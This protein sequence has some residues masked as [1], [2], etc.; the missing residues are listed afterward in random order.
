MNFRK[1]AG[2][3]CIAAAAGLLAA[4]C[5]S[6]VGPDYHPPQATLSGHWSDAGWSSAV[7]ADKLP[8]GAWWQIYADPQLDALEDGAEHDS[9]S[10]Q[11]ALARVRQA[12]ALTAV[13]RAA[14]GPQVGAGANASRLR[15][16]ANRDYALPNS[17]T[18]STTQN[19]FNA[20]LSAR[21]ETDLAGGLRRSIEAA[22][23]SA[24]QAQADAQTVRLL[25]SANVASNYFS[26]RALDA[27]IDQLAQLLA[28]QEHI[29]SLTRRRA[30]LGQGTSLEVAAQQSVVD[31]TQVQLD[32]LRTQRGSQVAALAALVGQPAPDFSLPSAPLA[33]DIPHPPLGVPADLLQ[34]RPDIASAE[35]AVAQASAQIGV[36]SAA[37]YPS[38]ALTGNAG[39]DSRALSSLFSAPSALWSL[40]A[41]LAATVYD[42]G[43]IDA[44]IQAARAAHEASVAHYRDTVLGAL[45]EV[46]GAL[47]AEQALAEASLR[48][49]TALRTAQQQLDLLTRRHQAGFGVAP[50]LLAAEQSVRLAEREVVQLRGQRL[51]NSVFLVKAL[52]GSWSAAAT[53]P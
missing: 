32:T 13:A 18:P 6:A 12:E 36:A 27:D 47:H 42:S 23:A 29:L 44:S 33:T 28:L 3:T 21:W 5:T 53:P 38:L 26:V 31:A 49:D 16:S 25:I 11:A 4:A 43:R 39:A 22:Q 19:D 7:P 51:L 34:R 2:T 41:S 50:D 17:P 48:Q 52:G 35:R 46:E 24:E 15:T 40:G 30:E 20:G 8:R 14:S 45:A 1:S 37:R 9:P 10:L